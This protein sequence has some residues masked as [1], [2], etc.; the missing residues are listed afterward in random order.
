MNPELL[1]RLLFGECD[2]VLIVSPPIRRSVLEF[3][4]PQTL[5]LP[6]L[7]CPRGDITADQLAAEAEGLAATDRWITEDRWWAECFMDRAE[8]IVSI[9]TRRVAAMARGYSLT[10]RSPGAT[11][12][13]PPALSLA[14]QQYPE[15]LIRVTTSQNVRQLRM[16]R[17][18]WRAVTTSGVPRSSRWGF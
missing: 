4:F 18:G 3:Y 1:Q 10:H 2:R 9:E 6:P 13:K 15:K 16:V 17:A 7:R 8:A 14:E 12:R 5:G 11:G